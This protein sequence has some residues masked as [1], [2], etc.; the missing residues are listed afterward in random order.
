MPFVEDAPEDADPL[1]VVSTQAGP[2]Q[3]RHPGAVLSDLQQAR[4][5]VGEPD[6]KPGA[7]MVASDEFFDRLAKDGYRVHRMEG[8]VVVYPPQK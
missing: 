4:R 8:R 3:S 2:W 7:L 6:A 5:A 1:A